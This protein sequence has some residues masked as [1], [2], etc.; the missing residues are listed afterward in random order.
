M[1]VPGED[2]GSDLSGQGKR[3]DRSELG[4]GEEEKKSLVGY[5]SWPYT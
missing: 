5:F 2:S 1:S 4:V 3:S